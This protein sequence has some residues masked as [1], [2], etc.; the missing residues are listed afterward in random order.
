MFGQIDISLRLLLITIIDMRCGVS[1]KFKL[2]VTFLG[3]APTFS[4]SF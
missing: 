1:S 4:P 2:C 3:L